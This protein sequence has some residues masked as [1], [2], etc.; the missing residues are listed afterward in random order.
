MYYSYI[1]WSVFDAKSIH[2]FFLLFALR[3]KWHIMTPCPMSSNSPSQLC[4]VSESEDDS[5]KGIQNEESPWQHIPKMKRGDK[6]MAW[7][8]W[9]W[10]VHHKEAIMKAQAWTVSWFSSL[11]SFGRSVKKWHPT[12]PSITPPIPILWS[13]LEM[14]VL[15]NVIG[16]QEIFNDGNMRI[17]MFCINPLTSLFSL[18]PRRKLSSKKASI[19]AF[20]ITAKDVI[21][22]T[23]LSMMYS[24]MIH[25]RVEA[26][27]M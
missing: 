11:S 10:G 26:I 14:V 20:W 5:N 6:M 16:G 19:H 9:G 1:A 21:H 4:Q 18:Y 2:S 27:S 3:C 12:S 17:T 8:P 25:K 23:Y 24:I 15:H 13:W 22:S 7:R